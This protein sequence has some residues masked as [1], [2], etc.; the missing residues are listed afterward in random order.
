MVRLFSSAVFVDLPDDDLP[1]ADCYIDDVFVAMLE[2]HAD[3]GA[4]AVP[5]AMHA[6]GRE[7]SSHE[8]LP[9]KDL[10]SITKMKA[11]STPSEIMIVLGWELDARRFTISLP[12][13]KQIAWK[14]SIRSVLGR[15]RVDQK[16]LDTIV[17]RLNHIGYVI[18]QARHF[19]S[20][21]RSL[22]KMARKRNW[23]SITQ[24]HK[25]DLRLWIKFIDQA[26]S[27]VNINLISL[28]QP[29]HIL[30]SDACEH[31]IGG[32]G[33]ESGVAWRFEIPLNLRGRFSINL[34]EHIAAH[35]AILVE[36]H[37][38]DIP[39]LSCVLSQ[40]D[41][42]S[43]NGWLYKSNFDEEDQPFHLKV[44]RRQ[45]TFC[46]KKTIK[47]FSQWFP[48]EENDVADSLSRD[49]HL[50][51]PQLTHSL[52]SSVPSQLSP[53]FLIKPLPKEISS[54]L[55]CLMQQST[56]TTQLLKEPTRSK[57]ARGMPGICTSPPLD[58]NTI[59]SS[60]ASTHVNASE[61]SELSPRPSGL[62]DFVKRKEILSS[63]A[64]SKP[65]WTTWLRP[66]GMLV[67]SIRPKMPMVET[68]SFY[69]DCVEDSQTQIPLPN[70][71]KQ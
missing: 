59:Y 35:V 63:V 56:P 57:L 47:L 66:S 16:T 61:S 27:G 50:S 40:V 45:A 53:N 11:E 1:M 14:D 30:R 17:G 20:R 38:N 29:T 25:D 54:W 8:P 51:V 43:S 41:S 58:S 4:A 3:R 36:D 28:R 42:T 44:A 49:H 71:K 2:Q 32:Y 69:E 33:L 62:D 10:L 34:L 21:L 5:L 12:A 39:P 37:Y 52:S 15:K 67:D 6:V 60:T 9:R 64:Q 31:G 18:P 65:P 24:V 48:G 46:I 68:R 23:V 22:L 7:S 19:L 26:A 13:H 55:I 70:N